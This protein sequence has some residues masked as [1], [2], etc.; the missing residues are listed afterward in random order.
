M[1]SFRDQSTEKILD[2][3]GLELLNLSS[4]VVNCRHIS[5]IG[6]KMARKLVQRRLTEGPFICRS[7]LLGVAGLGPKTFEQCA[8][9]L[10]IMPQNNSDHTEWSLSTI[11][12][13]HYFSIFLI[14]IVHCGSESWTCGTFLNNFGDSG[15]VCLIIVRTYH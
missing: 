9:F 6:E 14:I 13:T 5:G 1:S 8:G 12:V 7:Q 15:P 11:I 10:R 2:Y 3:G 4:Y